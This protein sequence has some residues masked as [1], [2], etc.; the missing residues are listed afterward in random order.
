[1][2]TGDVS[3]PQ[4]DYTELTL[5]GEYGPEVLHISID[6]EGRVVYEFGDDR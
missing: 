4:T 5:I 2:S 6:D 3:W 1:M